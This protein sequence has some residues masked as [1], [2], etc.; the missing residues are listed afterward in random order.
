MILE[1]LWFC[2]ICLLLF[3]HVQSGL[4]GNLYLTSCSQCCPS[5]F[6]SSFIC[7]RCSGSEQTLK[8]AIIPQE[9]AW[10]LVTDMAP[11]ESVWSWATVTSRQEN[12]FFFSH[13]TTPSFQGRN[14][15]IL[16]IGGK[17]TDKCLWQ[18]DRKVAV[19]FKAEETKK[20]TLRFQEKQKF[21][22]ECFTKQHLF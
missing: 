4:P 9:G 2:N 19:G 14:F 22:K 8:A 21:F 5:D 12:N 6:V 13:L 20:T 1:K 11:E 17:A 18:V 7:Q 3:I 10:L 16:L 15:I